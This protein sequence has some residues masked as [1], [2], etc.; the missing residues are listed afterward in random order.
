MTVYNLPKDAPWVSGLR[1]CLYRP[2]RYQGAAPDFDGGPDRWGTAATA[3]QAA[4]PLTLMPDTTRKFMSDR[5]I[6][7]HAR[8]AQSRHGR[9]VAWI[10]RERACHH[11]C[12]RSCINQR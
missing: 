7:L 4:K 9:R 10:V 6:S 12:K 3:H 1:P 2:V 11:Y 5:R 8:F